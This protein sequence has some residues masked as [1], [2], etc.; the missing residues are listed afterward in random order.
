MGTTLQ[1]PAGL[2][3][4]VDVNA[5][6]TTCVHVGRLAK[7]LRVIGYD[8]VFIRDAD[9]RDLLSVAKREGRI[10]VTLARDPLA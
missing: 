2:R 5:S 1:G 9:D 4:T 8:A 3:F 6:S 10:L 7:W